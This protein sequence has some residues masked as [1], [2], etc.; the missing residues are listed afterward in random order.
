MT[1]YGFRLFEAGLRRG[2]GR[3]DMPFSEPAGP[4][5]PWSFRDY[6]IRVLNG[7]IGTRERGLPSALVEGAATDV[8]DLAPDEAADLPPV[9]A[10]ERVGRMGDHVTFTVRYGRAAGHDKAMGEHAGD[11]LDIR[12]LAPSREYRG[13]LVVPESGL[14]AVLALETVGRLCPVQPCVRW[15][16]AWS[17][18]DAMKRQGDAQADEAPL[19]WRLS[20]AGLGDNDRLAAFMSGGDPTTVALVKHWITGDNRRRSRDL[21]LTAVVH[22]SAKT[23]VASRVATWGKDQF[24]PKKAADEIA[25]IVGGQSAQDLDFDDVTVMLDDAD[26]NTKSVTASAMSDIFT[27]PVGRRSPSS[28]DLLTAVRTEIEKLSEQLAGSYSWSGWGQEG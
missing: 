26:G 27:Y 28:D 25:K 22:P 21:Q 24:S 10:I 2:A 19:W 13:I 20:V 23:T 9:F 3:K 4:G 1:T 12:R 16:A 5:S 18:Y 14:T 17:R 7:R 15:F 8:D 11:D 6:L